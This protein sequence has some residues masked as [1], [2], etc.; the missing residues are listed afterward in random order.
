MTRLLKGSVV[1]LLSR[2]AAPPDRGVTVPSTAWRPPVLPTSYAIAEI[3][4]RLRRSAGPCA[5]ARWR[6]ARH[7]AKPEC[8][9]ASR[10]LKDAAARRPLSLRACAAD[11]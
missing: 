10:E 6:A 4:R 3:A 7:V 11:R 8:T 1:R 5:I 9:P 2:S